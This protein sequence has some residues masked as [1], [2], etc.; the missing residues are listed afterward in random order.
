MQIAST[1]EPGQSGSR[2][3]EVIRTDSRIERAVRLLNENS[4]RTLADLASGCTLSISRLSYLFKANTG[5]TVGVF[6][7]N[8]RFQAAM[9][10]LATTDMPI[11]Q[12]ASALGYHHTSSF[13]RAFDLHTG[14]SPS[15]YR[16]YEIR[17][18]SPTVAAS[19][20]GKRRVVTENSVQAENAEVPIIREILV[21]S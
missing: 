6:R 1:A 20:K 11:K 8:R 18:D 15:E 3:M 14:V 9:R 5:L 10:M 2:L 4:S 17:E 7:R 16:R 21:R 13:I 12:I 19:S